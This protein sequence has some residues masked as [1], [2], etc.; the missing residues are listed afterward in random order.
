MTGSIGRTR[1]SENSDL[2]RKEAALREITEVHG[3]CGDEK[4][5]E[6][7]AVEINHIDVT[8]D[9]QIG[10]A[11]RRVGMSGWNFLVAAAFAVVL[12]PS[13]AQ[14]IGHSGAGLAAAR[15]LCS[16][17]HAVE[18]AQTPSPETNAPAFQDIA[19]IPGMTTMALSAALNTSHQ[20]MPNIMLKP[21]EKDDIIAYILSLK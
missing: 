20:N 8:V 11:K 9:R 10:I 2:S 6:G 14:E 16:Q 18:T 15:R 7:T 12:N 5:W 3:A 21:E 1:G 17:C 13:N 4:S 19:A